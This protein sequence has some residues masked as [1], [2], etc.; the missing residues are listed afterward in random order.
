MWRWCPHDRRTERATLGPWTTAYAH[1]IVNDGDITTVTLDRPEK[2]N[3]LA[4][5]DGGAH[6][7]AGSHRSHRRPGRRAAANGPVFSAGHNFGD[8]AGATFD[9]ARHVF[10]APG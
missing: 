2:R 4:V 1:L 10:D 8:M 6:G 3:A 5:D 9:E 7:D